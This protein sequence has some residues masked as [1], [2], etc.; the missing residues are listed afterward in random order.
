MRLLCIHPGASISTADIYNGYVE[1]FQDLGHEVSGYLLDRRIEIAGGWLK[2]MWLRSDRQLPKPS[3][4]SILYWSGFPAIEMALRQTGV[5]RDTLAGQPG[6][7]QVFSDV[8]LGQMYPILKHRIRSR[9]GFTLRSR[10][11]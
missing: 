8:L 10:K 4:A 11:R 9:G 6:V 1:A 2:A 3:T 7:F 5:E